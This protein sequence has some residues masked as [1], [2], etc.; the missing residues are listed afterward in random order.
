MMKFYKRV[1]PLLLFLLS[2][3]GYVFAQEEVTLKGK[4]LDEQSGEPVVGASVFIKGTKF[5]TQ[6]DLDGN[7]EIKTTASLPFT[8][9]VSYVGYQSKEVE[10]YDVDE[11]LDVKL[12]SSQ[13]L[14]E[15]VIV[16]YGEQ[17]R[18]DITG[19]ISSVPTELK[20]QP[21]ASVERLLQGSVPGAIV[22]QT[23][24]QPGGGVSVQ[25]RGANSISASSEPLYVIDGFPVNNDYDLNDAGVVTGAKINPLSTLNTSD[26]E[27]IEVL[28][29]ASATAIYG[30]RGANGV[31]L[32]TTKRAKRNETSVTY[33]G[34]YGVQSITKT[35]DLLNGAQLW[36]LRKDAAFNTDQANGN[37]AATTKLIADNKNALALA[38]ANGYTLDTAGTGTDWQKAAFREA[39]IQSHSI[40]LLTGTD[41]TR[42]AFSGN[43]FNQEGILINT[44]FKRYTGRLNVDHDINARAKFFTS[45]VGSNSVSKVAPGDG[46][47][48]V[49]SALL[50]AAPYVPIYDNKGGY[51]LNTGS[52][53]AVSNPI[54]SLNNQ[55]NNSETT[56]F[57]ANGGID[58]KIL[59]GLT[60]R[61]LLGVDLV[62]NKQNRYL[63]KSTQE[64]L[65]LKGSA[66]IGAARTNNWLNEN[67]LTYSRKFN[68]V[69]SVNVVAGFM[70]QQS[71]S[72]VFTATATNFATDNLTYNSLGD[73][74]ATASSSGYTK[75][76][77]ASWLARVNY[78]YKDKY[79]LTLTARA[80]GSSRFGPDKKWGIFPSAA[81]G[82]NVHKEAFLSDVK[83][84]SNLKLRAS[85]GI[86]GN[87]SIS[88]YSSR[89]RLGYFNNNFNGNY[90]AGYAPRNN[91]NPNLG[92][93][94]TRQFDIGFDLGLF[95][96]RVNIV[97][98]YYDKKTTDLL[99]GATVS[100][101][102][103]WSV[104]NESGQPSYILQNIGTLSNKGVEVGVG[105]RNIDGK[106][107]K[108]NTMLV[109][110]TNKN[111][112]L[113][114]GNGVQQI[115][116]NSSLPS[117]QAVG[118]PIGSFIVYQTDGLIQPSNQGPTALTPES[119]KS[120][121]GQQY[122]DINGD[123]VITQAGDRIIIANNPG[124]S[125]GLTNTVNYKTRYGSL[126]LTVFL[127]T[128]QG[129]KIYNQN[130]A[131][132]ELSNGYTNAS[133]AVLNRY[134]ATNT[135]TDQKEAYQ[136][137]A[138]TISDRFIEDG[139]YWRLK[140][141]TLGYTLPDEWLSK[142]RIK[143]VRFYVSAQNWFTWTN[144]TGY[145][146]EVSANGQNLQTRGVDLGV[147]PNSKTI[148]G[149][150]TLAF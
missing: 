12:R 89:S 102:S 16:G 81:V 130:R 129:A 41:K 147:Y 11:P 91:P 123:G 78:D 21:V 60:A 137:A 4:L 48:S 5:G 70:A 88:P 99:L 68:K 52:D 138:I 43:Y 114:L 27:S 136:Q 58:Y 82:W 30:S 132:L 63:P 92:W 31:I 95:K 115:I 51:V 36:Q 103:G 142:V 97:F 119:N 96:D 23:T 26:I 44:G 108:W 144:Y 13:L 61:V 98:D 105:T 6:T 126:D 71:N 122:K 55:V 66:T 109:F 107:F 143:Q 118:Q 22:T 73:G 139:S 79:L 39:P 93:E 47:G 124:L 67:T 38:N 149:G 3:Q 110:S 19:S 35:I 104:M 8:V 28:K 57:L 80:D 90:V 64:G 121:G 15:V 141:I 86:T 120:A 7:Y 100:G 46:A 117:I 84:I 25:I 146:P 74:T 45:V 116:P 133:A 65:N 14:S 10:V 134:S 18:E 83:Q 54:N 140:N 150:M 2:L 111:K 125:F 53:N 20:T 131:Q 128:V 40:S 56:R 62:Y 135:N 77:L 148:L 37:T 32:V 145:D 1:I 42:V 75:W 59:P 49:T 72:E 87:Q 34:Y 9:I 112:I 76:A 24:G 50:Y 33:D 94:K 29:D 17:K 113:D 85:Y 101:T 127:Q 106:K 69:H